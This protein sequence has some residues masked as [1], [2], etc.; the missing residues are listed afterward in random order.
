VTLIAGGLHFVMDV[1]DVTEIVRESPLKRLSTTP[2]TMEGLM[3]YRGRLIPVIRLARFFENQAVN[4]GTKRILILRHRERTLGVLVD[5]V[6]RVG[7]WPKKVSASEEVVLNPISRDGFV[8]DD[9]RYYRL[10]PSTLVEG[11]GALGPQ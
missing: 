5:D 4:D 11:I 7:P 6:R 3:N 2:E 10:L 8:I 9:T 1:N